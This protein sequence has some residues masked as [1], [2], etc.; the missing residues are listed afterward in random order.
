LIFT[1]ASDNKRGL[2]FGFGCKKGRKQEKCGD[3][4]QP[5]NLLSFL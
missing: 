1:S 4:A 2:R 3:E 5:E